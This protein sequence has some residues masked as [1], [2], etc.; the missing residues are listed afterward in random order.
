MMKYV[1]QQLRVGVKLGVYIA[2]CIMI[3]GPATAGAQISDTQRNLFRDRILHFDF[4]EAPTCDITGG[5]TGNGGTGTGGAAQQEAAADIKNFKLTGD[6][7]KLWD[8]VANAYRYFIG[9]GLTPEQTAG[10]LG[11]FIQESGVDPTIQQGGAHTPDHPVNTVGFGIAQWTFSSRQDPLVKMA[12]D[13]GVK[14]NTLPVQLAYVWFEL[15]T[16]QKSSYEALTKT[17]TVEDATFEFHRVYEVSADTLA[18]IQ[19]RVDS[20]KDVLKRMTGNTAGTGPGVG[21]GDCDSGGGVVG[22]C[23][24]YGPDGKLQVGQMSGNAAILSCARLFDPYG[25][26]FGAGHEDPKDWMEKWEAQGGFKN[27]TFRNILDCSSLEMMAI[28]IAFG[29]SLQ[30]STDGMKDI[31]E[32]EEIPVSSAKPGDLMWRSGHTEIATVAGGKKTFGAHTANTAEKRQISD[33]SGGRWTSAFRY[34]GKGATP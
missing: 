19:E 29:V 14:P 24:P 5:T 13:N 4:D 32:L 11:N 21:S 15:Q 6:Q 9:K 8:R 17:T 30:F 2:L 12:T 28:Y 3:T 27:K 33:S 1:R 7:S 22:D 26:G 25:Y 10:I 16:S 23:Q 20:A 18:Q 31:P 34:K